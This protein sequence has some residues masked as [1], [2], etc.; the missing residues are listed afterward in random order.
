MAPATGTALLLIGAFVLPGFV[1]LLLRERAYVVPGQVS[2]FER[3]LTAL[4]Y[5]AVI[6][7]VLLAGG[8]ALGIDREG[9]S[10]LYQGDRALGS[11]L[12]ISLFGLLVLPGAIT[13]AGLG[14]QR[15]KRLRP[16]VMET[17][18]ISPAHSTPGAWDHF[19]RTGQVALVRA[20]LNDGR[21][22]AGYYGDESFAGYTAETP[23]LFLERRWTLDEDLWFKEEASHSLGL[24]IPHGSFVSVEFYDAS[25]STGSQVGDVKTEE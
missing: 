3:L 8:W 1:T 24:W 25:E 22:V 19:F 18:R 15:S 11:Y 17:A 13:A 6:Y 21:V 10:A 20:T 12:L 2:P 14:W 23:D 9:I 16:W 7:G 5:S 4:A